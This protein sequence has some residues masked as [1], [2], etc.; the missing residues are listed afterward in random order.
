MATMP[1]RASTFP[2]AF[3]S[4]IN[5]V[6]RLYLY[7]DGHAEVPE[8]THGD[9]RVVP[10]FASEQPG[11]GG[12][13]KYL[14]LLQESQPC[15][16]VGVDDDIIYPPDYV[17]HLAS[18]LRVFSSRCVVGVHGRQLTQPFKRYLR[19]SKVFHF[20][21]PLERRL[22]VDILGSGTTMFDTAVLQFDPRHWRHKNMTD[23]QL[24]LEAAKVR[25]P[26]ICVSRRAAFLRELEE[27][28]ADSVYAKLKKDDSIQTSLALE[29][30]AVRIGPD[31]AS[32]FEKVRFWRKA[33]LRVV[34][35]QL[36]KRWRF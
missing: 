31:Y 5:Q 21:R 33:N 9:P 36:L 1:S 12:D 18:E 24:A 30:L 23:I 2:K 29:L 7:L 14:G 25:L 13:G 8:C 16:Y 17:S 27:D 11:L 6:D 28:Q 4:I 3:L 26:M 35:K 22:R 10:I 19:D 15:L 34:V 32:R 20:T